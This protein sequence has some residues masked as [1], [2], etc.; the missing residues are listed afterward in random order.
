MPDKHLLTRLNC[1]LVIMGKRVLFIPMKLVEGLRNVKYMVSSKQV[2]YSQ[3]KCWRLFIF[4]LFS[5]FNSI[6]ERWNMHHFPTVSLWF[7]LSE[8]F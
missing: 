8:V 4:S 3:N 2:N 1:S 7:I 5:I 6:L